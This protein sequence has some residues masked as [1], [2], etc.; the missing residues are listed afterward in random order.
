MAIFISYPVSTLRLIW[1]SRADTK[2]QVDTG[3][4]MKIVI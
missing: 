3:Y 4:D 1:E 2:S